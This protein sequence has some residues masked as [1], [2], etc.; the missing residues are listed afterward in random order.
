MA[1]FPVRNVLAVLKILL[2]VQFSAKCNFFQELN[3]NFQT[4]RGFIL[5]RHPVLLFAPFF[6]YY[7]FVSGTLVHHTQV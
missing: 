7:N 3:L 4:K 2:T 1:L 5:P 6:T